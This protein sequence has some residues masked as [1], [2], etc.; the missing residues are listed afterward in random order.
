MDEDSRI[1]RLREYVQL[2]LRR[3]A[4]VKKDEQ[5]GIHFL[6]EESVAEY[7]ESSINSG[8][9]LSVRKGAKNERASIR[10]KKRNKIFS[11]EIGRNLHTIR[12]EPHQFDEVLSDVEVDSYPVENGIYAMV[13]TR[14]GKEKFSKVFLTPEEADTWVRNTA[15]KLSKQFIQ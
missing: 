9:K 1:K 12:Q 2:Y 4:K 8:K 5:Y 11:E 7:R 15:Y 14:D 10:N 3:K 6:S 13:A